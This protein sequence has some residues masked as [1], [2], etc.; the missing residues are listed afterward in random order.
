VATLNDPDLE[1]RKQRALESMAK[2]RDQSAVFNTIR[3]WLADPRLKPVALELRIRE[4][5]AA[6]DEAHLPQEE[7]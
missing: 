4:L 3:G 7:P 2:M 5:Y 6:Y 1:E